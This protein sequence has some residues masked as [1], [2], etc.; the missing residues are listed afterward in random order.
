MS[1]ELFA[2]LVTVLVPPLVVG[3]YFWRADRREARRRRDGWEWQEVDVR[4]N[5]GISPSRVSVREGQPIRLRF[6]RDDD[7]ESWWDDIEFPYTRIRRELP[8]GESVTLELAPLRA[9]DY[10][11]FAALGTMRGTVQVEDTAAERGW[12]EETA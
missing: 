5:G 1:S 8:E 9:G 12:E 4:V 6:I 3:V 2:I 11:L 7:G 10:A